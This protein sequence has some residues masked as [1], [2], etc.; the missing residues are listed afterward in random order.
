MYQLLQVL[1]IYI[2][3]I[4]I[5][6]TCH[7][8]Y[9]LRCTCARPN[10]YSCDRGIKTEP[11]FTTVLIDFCCRFQNTFSMVI[12]VYFNFD[13]L[14]HVYFIIIIIINFRYR[15][16]VARYITRA[17]TKTTIYATARIAYIYADFR[18]KRNDESRL[19][20]ELRL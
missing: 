1:T 4:I 15:F 6:Y 13:F 10:C 17:E 2:T 20:A 9:L 7:L 3:H 11:Y 19:T 5:L 8:V 14:V 12:R 16:R 18:G